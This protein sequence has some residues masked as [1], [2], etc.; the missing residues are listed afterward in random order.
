M[1]SG[2]ELSPSLSLSFQLR[3]TLKGK[4]KGGGAISVGSRLTGELVTDPDLSGFSDPGSNGS[5]KNC[6]Y[7]F[8]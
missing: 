4:K 6:C 1:S 7:E 3:P 2:T 8:T 5:V